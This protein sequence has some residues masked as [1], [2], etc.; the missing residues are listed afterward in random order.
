MN[1][2]KITKSA[3]SCKNLARSDLIAPKFALMQ[4]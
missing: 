2:R 3:R 1:N 4:N